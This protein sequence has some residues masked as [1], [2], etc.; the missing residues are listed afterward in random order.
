[1]S[2][3]IICDTA[4]YATQSIVF[5]ILSCII[6]G[7]SHFHLTKFTL[8]VFKPLNNI[9]VDKNMPLGTKSFMQFKAAAELLNATSHSPVPSINWRRVDG[10]P[11]HRKVD[12]RKASGVLEIPYFQQEDAGTYECVAEN[13]RGMNTVRGKLSFY[14][15]WSWCA[16]IFDQRVPHLS[17][18]LR[19]R[20]VTADTTGLIKQSAAIS[21]GWCGAQARREARFN[22]TS[23][24]LKAVSHDA[25]NI[26]IQIKGVMWMRLSPWIWPCI[27]IH[28]MA[29]W[30]TSNLTVDQ[31]L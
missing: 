9:L 10:A 27:G 13:S 30:L 28:Q 25:S 8:T 24:W 19:L 17:A 6:R 20:C 21:R 14:G 5:E 31:S 2:H 11:F 23:E 22:S 18:L 12:M 15:R 4:F 16:W 7:E 3:L 1:M 29:S 26:L